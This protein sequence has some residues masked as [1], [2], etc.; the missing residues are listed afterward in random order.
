MMLLMRF[1][2]SSMNLKV[3]IANNIMHTCYSLHDTGHVGFIKDVYTVR[4]N[5]GFINIPI[6]LF[7]TSLDVVVNFM[8]VDDTAMEGMY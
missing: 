3:S 8:T 1:S 5:E 4:E 7:N 6:Y 2:L